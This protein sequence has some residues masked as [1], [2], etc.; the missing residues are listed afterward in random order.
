MHNQVRQEFFVA[1]ETTQQPVEIPT[2]DELV[3]EQ[4]SSEILK[5][6]GETIDSVSTM[7][8]D[9][10]PLKDLGVR[11]ENIELLADQ[12]GKRAMT[13]M[14]TLPDPRE[15]APWKRRK[16][17]TMPRILEDAAGMVQAAVSCGQ[18]T[19]VLHSGIPRPFPL[20]P[21][22]VLHEALTLRHGAH[23]Y[24]TI[25]D[26]RPLFRVPLRLRRCAETESDFSFTA[27]VDLPNDGCFRRECFLMVD[28][29]QMRSFV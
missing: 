19:R 28:P 6:L 15:A 12:V 17:I 24:C 25:A 14:S 8:H 13:M 5:K 27:T 29:F 4:R 3:I 7:T 11:M 20:V 23:V 16:I 18:C 21:L 26:L 9:L 1:K 22:Q 2:D 10:S